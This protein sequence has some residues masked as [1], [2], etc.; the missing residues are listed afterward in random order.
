[1]PLFILSAVRLNLIT[2]YYSVQL[3]GFALRMSNHASAITAQMKVKRSFV[4]VPFGQIHYRY[5]GKGRPL[6]LLHSSPGSSRQLLPLIADM[7]DEHYI[8]APDTPGFGDSTPLP[9]EAPLIE[10]YARAILSFVDALGLVKIDVYGSHT[11]AAIAVELALLAPKL[12]DRII[13]DGIGVF[14]AKEREYFLEHYAKPFTPDLDGAYLLRAFQ[15]CRD[16]YLFY[17]WFEKTRAARRD[18]GIRPAQE[19]YAWLIE[20]LKAAETYHLGYRASFNWSAQMRLAL[21]AQPCLLAAA[22]NDPLFDAT[23]T[24]AGVVPDSRFAA[25]PRT[26]DPYFAPTRKKLF[27]NFLIQN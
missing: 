8:L 24:I 9:L 21:L 14:T 3:M 1:L 25:L 4:D 19:L 7:M 13:L 15:F 6:V 26:D 16:Q 2:D 27:H 18:A 22:Q 11:G 20:V 10:D 17:P 12:V 23:R 5:A